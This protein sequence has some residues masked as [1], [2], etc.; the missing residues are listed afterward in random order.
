MKFTEEMIEKA[1]AE[2]KTH[3]GFV[4]VMAHEIITY[5][6]LIKNMKVTDFLKCCDISLPHLCICVAFVFSDNNKKQR[7]EQIRI[8]CEEN[9]ISFNKYKSIDFLINYKNN[10][11]HGCNLEEENYAVFIKQRNDININKGDMEKTITGLSQK[12]LLAKEKK[13]KFGIIEYYS[14]FDIPIEQVKN[15]LCC[16]NEFK[17]D[18]IVVIDFI[19]KLEKLGQLEKID[20]GTVLNPKSKR[21]IINDLYINDEVFKRITTH[22][23]IAEYPIVTGTINYAYRLENEGNLGTLYKR[24]VKANFEKHIY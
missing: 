21:R 8:Y 9:E 22:L 16:V 20:V 24:K 5:D 12:L 1:Y 19:E 18:Y 14:Y 6:F 3:N 4:S 23:L 15:Y 17:S 7:Y 13:Q 11:F 2:F 10:N